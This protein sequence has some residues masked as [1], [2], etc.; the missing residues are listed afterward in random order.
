MR[1]ENITWLHLRNLRALLDKDPFNEDFIK[2]IRQSTSAETT[3]ETEAFRMLLDAAD[4]YF[5]MYA[6]G[7]VPDEFKITSA[8]GT[9]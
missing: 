5:F 4:A 1:K 7:L 9:K 8:V 2:V 6:R 3:V